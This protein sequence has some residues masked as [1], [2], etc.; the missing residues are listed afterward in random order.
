MEGLRVGL[1]PMGGSIFLRGGMF[2]IDVNQS[3]TQ[4]YVGLR[5][6]KH[7]FADIPPAG[8]ETHHQLR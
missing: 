4:P 8:L 7:M 5:V 1:F 3:D 6:G 2:H